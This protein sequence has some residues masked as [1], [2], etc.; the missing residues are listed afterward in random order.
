MTKREAIMAAAASAIDAATA[1]D[2]AVYRNRTDAVSADEPKVVVLRPIADNPVINGVG[3]IDSLLTVAV[4][5]MV[6]GS[7]A[8]MQGTADDIAESVYS[9][10]MV[11]VAGTMDITPKNSVWDYSGADVDAIVLTM[12]FDLFYR[13]SWGSLST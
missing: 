13:H 12:E 10:L 11:G 5:V 6:R 4:D 8:T 2:V 9:A 3:P 1:A 7:D